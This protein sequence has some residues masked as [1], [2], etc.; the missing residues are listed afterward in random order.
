MIATRYSASGPRASAMM[1]AKPGLG[2]GMWRLGTGAH[3]PHA[4]FLCLPVVVFTHT[5]IVRFT[6][7]PAEGVTVLR[8]CR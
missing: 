1:V 4:R 8:T 5:T 7:G 6:I 3:L 2:R